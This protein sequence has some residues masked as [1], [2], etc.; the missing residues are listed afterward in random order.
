MELKSFYA[1]K[2]VFLTGH[3]GFKGAWLAWWLSEL[4][5]ET[6]GYALAPEDLRG[7]LFAQT[8][9]A[10][11][12]RSEEG[13]LCDLPALRK[14]LDASRAEIVLHLAAQP[15]VIR[16]YED[17]VATYRSNALGT[18]CVMEAAR[19]CPSVKTVVVVTTDKCYENKE[20]PR[21]YVEEDA[22]GGH[23]PYSSSKAMAEIAV[24]AYRRSF[25][26]PKGVGLASARAGNVIGGGDYAPYRIVPDIV[27]A[28]RQGRPVVL[29]SPEA[30]R[31]WQHVLDALHGYLLL[32]MR[33]HG[34]PLEYASAY[35]F[36]PSD[37]S[38]EKH[39]VLA[40]ADR[41]IQVMGQGS[42]VIDAGTQRGHEA[43]YLALDPAKAIRELGWKPRLS[44]DE[45][46]RQTAEWTLAY[47][48]D[49]AGARQRT[50]HEI[51]EFMVRCE[52][53]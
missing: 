17:P 27:E 3:T 37:T 39:N 50:L 35:N 8:A 51:R 25:F 18:V 21:P 26:A 11:A 52:H 38:R 41:F 24:S 53:V 36:S 10:E 43:G 45:A 6:T 20:Q 23:D 22:L 33:L 44:T 32:A 30:V 14:A 42:R 12:I 1:G 48:Q 16:S 7:N 9:L 19:L 46:L 31:P 13:D 15:L 2:K 28:I 49:P 34:G 5:A 4:G 40:I 29:R 47:F